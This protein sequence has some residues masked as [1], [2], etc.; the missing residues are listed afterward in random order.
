[1]IGRTERTGKLAAAGGQQAWLANAH[2]R[3]RDWT[4]MVSFCS[5]PCRLL[6][7]SLLLFNFVPSAWRHSRHL[8]H[9]K[10]LEVIQYIRRMP[11]AEE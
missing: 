3:G 8:C 4:W 9:A 11:R 1:M 7:P 10:S 5:R 6:A 2:H